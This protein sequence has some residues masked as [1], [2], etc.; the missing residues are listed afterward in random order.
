MFFGTPHAGSGVAKKL[1]IQLLTQFAK[2]S[3]KKVPK[4]IIKALEVNS[5]E[6]LE[7]SD[8]FEKSTLFTQHEVAICTYYETRT[9]PFLGEEVGY[10]QSQMDS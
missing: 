9:T 8:N 7:L 1:R 2:L 6:L 5:D 4:K 10:S 3:F